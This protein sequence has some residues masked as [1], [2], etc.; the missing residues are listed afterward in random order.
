[1][2]TKS[3]RRLVTLALALLAVSLVFPTRFC[4]TE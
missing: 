3:P 4:T 1:V 2:D